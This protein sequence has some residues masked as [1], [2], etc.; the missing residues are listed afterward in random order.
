MSGRF[1]SQACGYE[2][3]AGLPDAAVGEIVRS[4]QLLAEARADGLLLEVGA[5]IGQIGYALGKL[6][7]R[8]VGFDISGPMLEQ[9]RRR[10]AP[11]DPEPAVIEA[12]GNGRW[13]VADESTDLV[14]S[15]RALHLLDPEH[16]VG[17]LFRVAAP[18][19]AVVLTGSVRRSADSVKEQMRR[20]MLKLLEEHGV[21]GRSREARL[22][23]IFERCCAV[24]A[25]MMKP[26][27]AA[28]WVVSPAPEQSI[29][30]WRDQEGLAGT[31]VPA[32]VKEAVLSRLRA[33]A[34][35]RYDDLRRPVE[36][37]ESYVLEGV[38]IPSRKER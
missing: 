34:E 2:R 17:E 18:R 29:E 22:R 26:R 8:Y 28:S 15:S 12:D 7:L 32:R 3:R 20:Q 6:P 21:A 13:P 4:I 36:M 35:T 1:D 24:G 16:V 5:G 30:A 23:G 38:R 33:W 19:G 14:F 31:E 9:F 11:G 27:V 37:G 10:F 25:T